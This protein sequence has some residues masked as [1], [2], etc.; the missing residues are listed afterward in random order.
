MSSSSFTS[1][2]PTVKINNELRFSNDEDCSICLGDQT[3][4][5][6][7]LTCG[8]I[9]HKMCID[10][11]LEKNKTC[12]ICR[13]RI[14]GPYKYKFE[15][16]HLIAP[17]ALTLVMG[18]LFGVEDRRFSILPLICIFAFSAKGIFEIANAAHHRIGGTQ[19]N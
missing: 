11:W 14:S 17:A 18:E 9:F 13:N 4:K 12:P 16:W 15:P 5:A 1:S 19:L 7:K 6:V 10:P 3:N 2:I 8:H